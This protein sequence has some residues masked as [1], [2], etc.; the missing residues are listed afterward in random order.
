MDFMMPEMNG[1]E[2]TRILRATT[3]TKEIPIIA[4][5]AIIRRADV[6]RCSEAGCNDYLAKPFRVEELRKRIEAL[7]QQ[8]PPASGI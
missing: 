4:V 8:K 7:I 1:W 2:A 5:T 6:R 3:E